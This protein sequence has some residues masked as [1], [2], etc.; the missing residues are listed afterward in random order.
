[1]ALGVNHVI[2]VLNLK[3]GVGKTHTA[4]LLAA[5]CQERGKRILL[6]DTDTQG[7]LRGSTRRCT[8]ASTAAVAIW[9]IG[10]RK[11]SYSCSL[12]E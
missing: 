2:T 7:N 4:W 6:I 9:K 5:V 11:R 8:N 3:G 12:I 1:M 10:L